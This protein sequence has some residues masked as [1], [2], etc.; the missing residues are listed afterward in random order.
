[1]IKLNIKAQLLS[2]HLKHEIFHRK[3]CQCSKF[4]HSTTER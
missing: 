2:V 3:L 1:M 4:G